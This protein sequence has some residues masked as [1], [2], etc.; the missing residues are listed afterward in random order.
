[1]GHDMIAVSFK[2]KLDSSNG[3]LPEMA[4]NQ[5]AFHS[6]SVKISNSFQKQGLYISR[7][8]LVQVIQCNY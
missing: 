6:L 1:M 7:I 4:K 2:Y 3:L 5:T 8:S